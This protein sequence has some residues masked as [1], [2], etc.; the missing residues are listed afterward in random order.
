MPASPELLHA[1]LDDHGAAL[2]KVHGLVPDIDRVARLLIDTFAAGGMVYTFGNGGS[3]ADAQHLSG[4]LIGHYKRERRPL[5]CLTL[6]ADTSVLTC[7]ANDYRYDDV[8]ARQV[9]ALARPGVVVVAFSTSGRSAN[10]VSALATAKRMGATTVLFGGGDGGPAR[11]FAD[12]VLLSP[13]TATARIQEMHTT[14]MHM[15]SELV[16]A[17]AAGEEPQA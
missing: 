4:E 3:A 14:M 5:P 9:E 17:W 10:I 7:T 8:F 2:E 11:D 15:I 6:S 13:S 12:Q 16:D 1:I